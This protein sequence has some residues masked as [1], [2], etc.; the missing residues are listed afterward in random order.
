MAAS[1]TAQAIVQA[2]RSKKYLKDTQAALLDYQQDPTPE[3]AAAA[4]NE[5]V[6]P[7]MIMLGNKKPDKDTLASVDY[8]RK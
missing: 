8:D 4:I 2:M 3:K 6:I 7:T 5:H 1:K